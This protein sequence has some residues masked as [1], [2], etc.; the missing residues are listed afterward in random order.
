[1]ILPP[2][3]QTFS[4]PEINATVKDSQR[5]FRHCETKFFRRK[6][7]IPPP[8]YPNFFATG[9]Y[10]NSK[11]FPYGKFPHCETKTFRRKIL[12]LPPLIQTFS[13]PETNATVKDSPTDF[14][15]LSDKIFSTENIDT[16]PFYPNFFDTRR[17]CN[18]KGLPYGNF[19]H[20]ET[21]NFR[22]KIVILPPLIQTFSI[23]EIN[24]TVKDSLGRFSAL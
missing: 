17:K 21:K 23:P 9:N 4:I 3:I 13:I 11:G 20:C 18:I 22:Q 8:S 19:R 24:A 16:P 1:M 2:L 12:I 10:C 15:A 5:T 14:S 6:I 7:L